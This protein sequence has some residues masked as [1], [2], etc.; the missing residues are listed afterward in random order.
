MALL[1]DLGGGDGLVLVILVVGRLLL[2][3]LILGL[4]G[5]V[6]SGT[7]APAAQLDGLFR[8]EFGVAFGAVGRAT[9][10]VV[11]LRLAVRTDLLGAKFGSATGVEPLAGGVGFRARPLPPPGAAVKSPVRPD[12]EVGDPLSQPGARRG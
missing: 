2:D 12:R 4:V 1:V 5:R 10:Q 7:T 9:A 11:E 3:D 6:A 8:I